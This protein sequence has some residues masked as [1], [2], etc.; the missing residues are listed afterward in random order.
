MQMHHISL[1][2]LSGPQDVH[3]A[4]GGISQPE[5]LPAETIMHPYIQSLCYLGPEIACLSHGDGIGLLVT[6][7][8]TCLH[9]ITAEGIIESAGSYGSTSYALACTYREYS[10]L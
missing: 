3:P 7:Q 6:H 2:I 9:T 4:A 8:H 5:A 1:L 10:H